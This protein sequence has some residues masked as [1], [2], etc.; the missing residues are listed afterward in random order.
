MSDQTDRGTGGKARAKK[1]SGNSQPAGAAVTPKPARPKPAARKP[2][3]KRMAVGPPVTIHVSFPTPS[4][5]PW[6][7]PFQALG[8]ADSTTQMGPTATIYIPSG[9]VVGTLDANPPPPFTW[10]YT[11]TDPLPRGVPLSL[12]VSGTTGSG[13]QEQVVVPF[14]CQ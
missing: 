10:S 8:T 1:L 9:S 11:F 4:V 6:S 14:Q 7:N 13:D 2:A 12:V 5:V 3:A